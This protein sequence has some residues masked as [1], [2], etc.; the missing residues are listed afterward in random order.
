[1]LYLALII[2]QS[3]VLFEVI[4]MQKSVISSR[5]SGNSVF[6][7]Y[8]IYI[9]KCGLVEVASFIFKYKWDLQYQ[10]LLFIK[11]EIV[12]PATPI[13]INTLFILNLIRDHYVN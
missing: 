7:S 3:Y 10:L 5:N 12:I 1:M 4:L 6:Y 2:K 9:I 11:Q 8:K 13:H